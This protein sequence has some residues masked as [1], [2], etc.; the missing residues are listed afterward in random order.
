M[1]KSS[2]EKKQNSSPVKPSGKRLWVL[3]AFLAA[4]WA[5]FLWSGGVAGRMNSAA[6][7]AIAGRRFDDA[8]LWLGR[9]KSLSTKNAECEFL[10]ARLARKQGQLPAMSAHL[11]S[12]SE[13]GYDKKTLAREQDLALASIGRME[14]G[15]EERLQAWLQEGSIDFSEIADAYANGLT[16]LSRFDDAQALLVAWQQSDPKEPVVNYRRARIHEHFRQ[17]DQAEQEYRKSVAKDPTFTKAKYHLARLLLQLRQP[18]EALTLFQACEDGSTALAAETGVGGCYRNQGEAEKARDTLRK[19]MEHSFDEVMESYRTVD[20]SPERYMPASELGCIETEL[21]EFEAAR[22]NLEL[23]LDKFPR[24]TIARYSYGVTLRSLGFPKEAEEQ[25][26]RTRQARTAL[27]EVSALQEELR[28][29]PENTDA[30]L[31]I[32]KIVLEHESEHT[33]IFWIQSVFSYDP[34]NAAAHQALVDYYESKPKASDE[35]KKLAQYHR[36]FLRK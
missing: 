3:L 8:Q 33:G 9:S 31:K 6:R 35:D 26:E 32:G 14:D 13:L 10:L 4:V 24:D 11:H 34:T 5:V 28:K 22:K 16:A 27:D 17:P 18:D 7:Q 36:S 21:G 1:K 29:N 20:E 25:F 2:K 30:R 23:A 19:V 12:A 15:V